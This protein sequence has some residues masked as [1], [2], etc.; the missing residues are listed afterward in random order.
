[1]LSSFVILVRGQRG[2]RLLIGTSGGVLSAEPASICEQD[3][4]SDE[5]CSPK[6]ATAGTAAASPVR[7]DTAAQANESERDARGR[8]NASV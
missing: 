1:M 3:F 7:P 8:P 6:S 4:M 5:W 2:D